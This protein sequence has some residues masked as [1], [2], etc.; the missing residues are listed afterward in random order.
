MKK[1]H[2]LL[3]GMG[4]VTLLCIGAIVFVMLGY[5]SMRDG[6]SG[7]YCLKDP[8][9]AKHLCD[10]YVEPVSD[11]TAQARG[12]GGRE[13][14]SDDYGMLFEFKGSAVRCFWME[15]MRFNIDIVWLDEDLKI[16][17]KEINVSP[18]TYPKSFC[19]S[20]RAH[21]VLEVRANRAK[22]WPLGKHVVITVPTG[23]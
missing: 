4:I 11:P 6:N 2:V 10:M 1:Y 9:S 5:R 20:T 8:V 19:P 23:S 3:I 18:D 7:L 13:S 14:I 22:D 21:S 12:L 15:H 16:V 17:A